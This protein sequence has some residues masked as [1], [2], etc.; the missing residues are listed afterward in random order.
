MPI[1]AL[2]ASVC[3]LP[4]PT[5]SI[6]RVHHGGN[7]DEAIA[8]HPNAPKPWIDLSTGINPTPYPFPSLPSDAWSRLP[9]ATQEHDLIEAAA[10][11]Y[12]V[13]NPAG[14][15]ASPGTQALIQIIPKLVKAP[16]EVAI[17]GPTYA[18]HAHCWNAS[19]HRVRIITSLTDI[20]QANVVIC[21]NP[22]NPTGAMTPPAS[23]HNIAQHL[24][25]TDGLLVVDEAFA[26]TMPEIS[27]ASAC[28]P[29]TLV[30]KSFGKFYGLAGLRLGFAI[31]ASS[32]CSQLKA[33]LGPWAISGPAIQIGKRAL[34]DD[35]WR[36][37]TIQ[38]LIRSRDH[39]TQ[40][41]TSAGMKPIGITPLFQLISHPQAA[42]LAATLGAS[43][44]HV[45]TFEDHPT[46]L[47]F[48]LP[49]PDSAWL[50]LQRVLQTF[51]QTA[52]QET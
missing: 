15:V 2:K 16:A 24:H 41:L 37:E 31:G 5:A 18:E 28:P 42:Q 40:L 33:M 13:D 8:A 19:G 34:S 32:T 11:C 30:L 26:D 52:H 38:Q 12:G 4:V 23:L 3:S 48:G 29:G 9:T 44:I 51:A 17:L 47:R 36:Q 27:L 46:W 45:R 1:T 50:R 21:V 22:N 20:G 6:A 10:R 43:G 14:I 25:D 49:G 39:L 35:V 7:L